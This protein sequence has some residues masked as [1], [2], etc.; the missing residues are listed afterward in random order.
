V[1]GLAE[2]VIPVPDDLRDWVRGISVA[3]VD[4]DGGTRTVVDSPDHATTLALRTTAGD[5]VVMGPRT[6]ALYHPAEPGPSC[7]RIRLQPGRARLVLGAAPQRLVNWVVP[8]A[9]LW[10][11]PG[12]R[13][14]AALADL[15]EQ[16][17]L[18]QLQE[19]LLS[20]LA[21]RRPGELHQSDLVHAASAVL[22]TGAERVRDTA[23]QLKISE[24]QLRTLFA[25]T[26]GVSPKHFA[27]IDRVRTVL[28]RVRDTRGA[29]L[30]AD[31][32]YYDQSHMSAEFREVMGVRPG[33]FIA[34]RLPAATACGQ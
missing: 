34:G 26:V 18:D 29:Q 9:D 10:G 23:W 28:A 22:S 30:A 20:R 17:A 3:A 2:R 14:A 6:R 4:P 27:R 13:L 24:R 15:G 8:L 7:V 11:E 25:E 21:T 33:A 16:A 19:M 5:A 12:R 31:A 1:N 32:G